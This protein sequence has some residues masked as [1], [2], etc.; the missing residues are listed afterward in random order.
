MKKIF[1]VLLLFLCLML[2]SCGSKKIEEEV[3]N[4]N[5]LKLIND[6]LIC[7]KERDGY[8]SYLKDDF[9]SN[10]FVY[11]SFKSSEPFCDGVAIVQKYFDEKYQLIDLNGNSTSNE[12]DYLERLTKDRYV[13]GLNGYK[14]VI[15]KDGSIILECFYDLIFYTEYDCFLVYKYFNNKLRSGLYDYNGNV[16]LDFDY[17]D[18]SLK[19]NSGLIVVK[20]FASHKCGYVDK[21]GNVVIPC[22]YDKATDFSG[23]NSIVALNNRMFV[24]DTT[25]KEVTECDITSTYIL[26]EGFLGRKASNGDVELVNIKT[27]ETLLSYAKITSFNMI[28]GEDYLFVQANG[29]NNHNYL[30]IYN[31]IDAKLIETID[32]S[33]ARTIMISKDLDSDAV[34]ISAYC[35]SY[36]DLYKVSINTLTKVNYTLNYS[37]CSDVQDGLF[38]VYNSKLNKYGVANLNSEIIIPALYDSIIGPTAD[39]YFVYK[40]NDYYGLKDFSGQTILDARYEYIKLNEED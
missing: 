13:A 17:E 20:D 23:D 7:V 31:K 6:G 15:S 34:Y 32:I 37:M 11:S 35:G 9:K 22:V 29:I 38:I 25:G 24:I 30:I 27:N 16:I 21:L 26:I 3:T 10:F 19:E 39:G 40:V 2:A 5:K 4:L 12:Y 36:T 8:A 28:R 18:I 33:N 14:G 1:I